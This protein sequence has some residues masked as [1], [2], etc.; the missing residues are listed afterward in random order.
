[1]LVNVMEACKAVLDDPECYDWK[2]AIS[3]H[4]V[5]HTQYRKMIYQSGYLCYTRDRLYLDQP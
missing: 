5:T 4:G 1:M 2:G 3:R